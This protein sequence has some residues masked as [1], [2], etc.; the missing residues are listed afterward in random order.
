MNQHKLI[1]F[2]NSISCKVLSVLFCALLMA[3][4][5][6]VKAQ[7]SKVDT[8]LIL[9]DPNSDVQSSPQLPSYDPTRPPVITVD[10]DVYGKKSPYFGNYIVERN[11]TIPTRSLGELNGKTLSQQG[12]KI[13][14][15]D[16]FNRAKQKVVIGGGGSDKT[17]ARYPY[18]V[19]WHE[20]DCLGREMRKFLPFPSSVSTYN[21][22]ATDSLTKYYQKKFGSTAIPYT[23]AKISDLLNNNSIE[24]SMA[25]YSL[26]DGHNTKISIGLNSS[27]EVPYRKV[28][29]NGKLYVDG[30]YPEGSLIRKEIRDANG[31]VNVVFLAENNREIR[32][33][34]DFNGKKSTTDYVYDEFDRLIWI[35]PPNVVSDYDNASSSSAAQNLSGTTT[36]SSA[37]N[38]A[39]VL[40][41]SATMTLQPGFVGSPGFS[42]TFST[43]PI[44]NLLDKAYYYRYD[45]LGRLVCKKLPDIDSIYMVYDKYNRLVA[46]QDGNLRQ[47]KKWLYVRYDALNR[48]V[49]T[50]VIANGIQSQ[51]QM[52]NIVDAAYNS[53]SYS[54]VESLCGD[55]YSMNSFPH[56]SD[57]II[58]SLSYSYYDSY[59]VLDCPAFVE[60]E[61]Y[62]N[63]VNDVA[64]LPIAVKYVNLSD[65]TWNFQAFYYND[66]L[67]LIQQV[68]RRTIKK[69]SSSV[70]LLEVASVQYDP[71]TGKTL[72]ERLTQTVA[73]LSNTIT[74]RYEYYENDLLKNVYERLNAGIEEQVASYTYDE[75]GKV[76]QKGYGYGVQRSRYTYDIRG[77]LIQ[78]N[79]PDVFDSS[80]FFSMRIGYD[81]PQDVGINGGASLVQYGIKGEYCGNVSAISWRSRQQD[82]TELKRGYAFKYDGLNRLNQSYFA[83]GASLPI[84][85]AYTEKD[86]TY[87]LMGNIKTLTRTGSNGSATTTSYSYDGNKLTSVTGSNIY[88]YDKNGNAIFDGKSGFAIEYNELNLPK[89]VSKGSDNALYSYN[90][91]GELQ[92]VSNP[93]GSI[94]YYI[95]SMVYDS[96]FKLL[97]IQG[98]EGLVLPNG[99]FQYNLADHLG[100]T[101]V[102]FS[103]AAGEG[104]AAVVEQSTDYYPYGKSFDNMN[105]S[106]NP[107][108]YSGKELQAQVMAGTHF[109]WYNYGAR[110]YD[111]EIGIWHSI[112]P[113]SE[114]FESLSPYLYAESNPICNV[115]PDGQF[116]T[117]FGAWLY[118]IF[119][120]GTVFKDPLGE[121]G[122]WKQVANTGDASAT[123]ERRF[124]W[125]GRNQG[126]DVPSGQGVTSAVG[127]FFSDHFYVGAEGEIS[128]GVQLAGMI[129]KGVGVNI[130]PV[131]QIVAEGSIS[132]R[133]HSVDNYS[134]QNAGS[135]DKVK[136]MDFGV[137]WIVGGNYNWNV[138]NGQMVSQTASLGVYGFG[139][140]L[141]WDKKGVTNLFVGFELGGKV[142]VG[143][144][145]SGSVKIGFTWNFK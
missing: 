84:S 86:I 114:D 22:S 137:A 81:K 106:K 48:T 29:D 83:D 42:V 136:A 44:D 64:G 57:G 58:E 117:Q 145:A 51:Q 43:D 30:Y 85:G 92:S 101:R 9:D 100:S 113:R 17:N 128:Y 87:D 24:T 61:K 104:Q 5:A 80:T 69:E 138:V 37:S 119:Y 134:I 103:K 63:K 129:K 79:D 7:T 127:N 139:G 143:W 26:I 67:R 99:R 71:F 108:L 18:S 16:F 102:V 144:G 110:F 141:T 95:S 50:G 10:F 140:N 23:D 2:S 3:I 33:I 32:I 35:L 56:S 8:P 28:K 27:D 72:Q 132:N 105:V 31:K 49:E 60:S 135:A 123:V 125:S 25:G 52:Q 96:N 124:D 115:D 122:V 75:F 40:K 142:A 98:S 97:Y 62:E 34:E 53:S 45:L 130:N 36:L 4:G 89:K 6:E 112:D 91:D 38:S 90:A 54:I 11:P 77:S 133:G 121:W 111:P 47:L 19:T 109:D 116:S 88:R 59:S 46:S 74:N 55:K 107:Y 13:T 14:Y 94:R 93:D 78:I 12:V 73:G 39:Y 21:G 126:K 20:Y 120:G 68:T 76:L 118:Q 131:S 15:L 82:G 1:D 70:N 41:S 66:D 65:K